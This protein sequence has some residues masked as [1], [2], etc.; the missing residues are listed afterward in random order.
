[1]ASCVQLRPSEQ[2]RRRPVVVVVDKLSFAGISLLLA[3]MKSS[4]VVFVVGVAQH[5][6]LSL[7]LTTTLTTKKRTDGRTDNKER[8][9]HNQARAQVKRGALSLSL[10]SGGSRAADANGGAFHKTTRSIKPTKADWTRAVCVCV[11][12]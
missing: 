6:S 4:L 3:T 5:K 2:Q 10:T 9:D 7:T 1:M 12:C 11:R 8:I